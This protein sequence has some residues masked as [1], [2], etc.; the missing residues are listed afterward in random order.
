MKLTL[1]DKT[2][3]YSKRLSITK[4]DRFHDFQLLLHEYAEKCSFTEN[5]EKSE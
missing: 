3:E 1:F 2:S 4:S 5:V